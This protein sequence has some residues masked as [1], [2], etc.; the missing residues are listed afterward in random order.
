MLLLA[1]VAVVFAER[2]SRSPLTLSASEARKGGDWTYDPSMDGEVVRML[3]V[4]MKAG[5]TREV[6][7]ELGVAPLLG[8]FGDM[9][10]MGD[11]GAEKR[12]GEAG[13]SVCAKRSGCSVI[14]TA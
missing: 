8:E 13:E 4:G 1:V 7:L 14:S 9:M 10:E 12:E 5:T 3:W 2:L 6:V 11:G